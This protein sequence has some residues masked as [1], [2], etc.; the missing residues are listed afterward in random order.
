MLRDGRGVSPDLA[1]AES[2][3]DKACKANVA[4]ACTNVGDLDARLAKKDGAARWKQAI[5]H[6]KS[7][8]DSC[9]AI[10][11]RQIGILYLDGKGLPKSTSAAAVWLERACLPDDAV[12]CRL[13]GVMVA[14]GMGVPRDVER[15]K[16]LLGR[17]CDAKH[18]EACR[19][20]EAASHPPTDDGGKPERGSG[21]SG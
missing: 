4:F 5:A 6:Y 9:D 2:L 13:L 1:R 21:T 8:C 18:D 7:G 11:C 12:A 16:Q 10:A 3:L 20:L 14:E 17:A 19:L 15:G